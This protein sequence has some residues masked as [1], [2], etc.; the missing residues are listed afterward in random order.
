[1]GIKEM[2]I[3]SFF[4]TNIK[5]NSKL[6]ALKLIINQIKDD[7]HLL[8]AEQLLQSLIERE[9]LLSTEILDGIHIPHT[10]SNAVEGIVVVY[11]KVEINNKEELFFVILSNNSLITQYIKV[12]SQLAKLLNQSSFAN[13]IKESN[14]IEDIQHLIQLS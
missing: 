2:L 6:E 8:D 14:R 3:P 4:L 13:K 12:I 7:P 10:K 9:S 11:A 1:M 5:A